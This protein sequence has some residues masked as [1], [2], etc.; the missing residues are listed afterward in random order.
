MAK[1]MSGPQIFDR[2][3][4]FDLVPG[5]TLAQAQEIAACMRKHISGMHLSPG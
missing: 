3:L 5:T 1:Q 4:G 2:L